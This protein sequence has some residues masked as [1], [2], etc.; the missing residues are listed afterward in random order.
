MHVILTYNK[1][2]I[3]IN[4]DGIASIS[5]LVRNYPVPDIE[6]SFE[7]NYINCIKNESDLQCFMLIC[8]HALPPLANDISVCLAVNKMCKAPPYVDKYIPDGWKTFE[9]KGFNC[10]NFHAVDF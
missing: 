5:T 2:Q 6:S 10:L 3:Q 4:P 8:R 1:T 7:L 9:E